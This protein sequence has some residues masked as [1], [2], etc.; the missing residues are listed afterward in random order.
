MQR[1]ISTGLGTG[2]ATKAQILVILCR[3]QG[4]ELYVFSNSDTA[5]L[6]KTYEYI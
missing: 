4:Y 2:T 1:D 5:I 6:S 3:A